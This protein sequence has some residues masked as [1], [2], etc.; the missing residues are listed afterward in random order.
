MEVDADAAA[1]GLCNQLEVPECV[2]RPVKYKEAHK[3]LFLPSL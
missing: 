3:S 2:E 1:E